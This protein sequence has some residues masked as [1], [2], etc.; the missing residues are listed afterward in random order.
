LENETINNGR[1]ES[2]QEVSWDVL[3]KTGRKK[4]VQA[5]MAF[6][7]FVLV[8]DFDCASKF[9]HSGFGLPCHSMPRPSIQPQNIIRNNHAPFIFGIKGCLQSFKH[10]HN[11]SESIEIKTQTP[12]E[13]RQKTLKFLPP[14]VESEFGW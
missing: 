12:T 11:R 1:T 5:G 9:I 13:F 8:P 10:F 2:P 14:V 7:P 3:I 6:N 4:F